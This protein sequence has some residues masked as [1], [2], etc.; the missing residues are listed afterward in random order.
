MLTS[1]LFTSD[2]PEWGTP[3]GFFDELERLTAWLTKTNGLEQ[4][5]ATHHMAE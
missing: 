5:G 2:T 1:G 4:Y 3:Q